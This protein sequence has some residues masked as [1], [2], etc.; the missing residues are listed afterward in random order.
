MAGAQ[1]GG[2][3]LTKEENEFVTRVGPGTPMGELYRRFWLPA[4]LAEELPSPDCPPV[5]LT[6][7][8]E[9]LVA[10]KDTDGRIGILDA[11]R[12][13]RLVHLYYGRN[14]ECGLRCV[15]HC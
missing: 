12:R 15:Y 3:M 7:L 1:T 9:R 4:L 6:I 2:L 14:E 8:N 5:R 10:F 11:Y 13:H